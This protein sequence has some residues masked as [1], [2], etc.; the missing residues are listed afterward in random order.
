MTVPSGS[1]VFTRSAEVVRLVFD[2]HA[3]VGANRVCLFRVLTSG[4]KLLE[5]RTTGLQLGPKADSK[6]HALFT[7]FTSI[8][9]R[10]SGT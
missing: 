7:P 8:F 2:V 3:G 9:P 4:L 10:K 6:I 5:K 1:I